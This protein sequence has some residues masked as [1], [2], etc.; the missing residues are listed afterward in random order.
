LA[1]LLG[2]VVGVGSAVALFTLLSTLLPTQ[3]SGA[4]SPVAAVIRLVAG[5]FFLV[6]AAFQWRGR[7]AIGERAEL[8]KW[9]TSM[10]S[11]MPVKALGLGLVLSAVV[12]K[13]LLLAVSA[14]VIVGEPQ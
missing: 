7:P 11:M 10:N 13:N 8:P 3:D 5:V 4:P 9:T 14:G 1:L 6:L 2:C 12:P